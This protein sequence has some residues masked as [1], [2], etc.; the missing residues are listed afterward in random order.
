MQREFGIITIS[1][2]TDAGFVLNSTDTLVSHNLILRAYSAW[3]VYP[4]VLVDSAI[5]NQ[6]LCV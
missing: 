3:L 1:T 2:K 4:L 5:A 6:A